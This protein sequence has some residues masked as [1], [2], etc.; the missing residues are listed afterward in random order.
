[1]RHTKARRLLPA[2]ALAGVAVLLG[3]ALMP[4]GG[5]GGLLLPGAAALSIGPTI[6]HGPV[7]LV[8][9]TFEGYSAGDWVA[10]GFVASAPDAR[11]QGCTYFPSVST[12]ISGKLAIPARDISRAVGFNITYSITA[13][14][15]FL[16]LLP[17]GA[18]G[19]FAA[20]L[21][22]ARER[23]VTRRG[24]CEI[25]TTHCTWVYSYNTV[26]RAISPTATVFLSRRSVPR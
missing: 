12:A 22:Y 13:G 11:W 18:W 23:V 8:K 15:G 1:M 26:Q 10:C 7:Q 24:E 3:L 2:S 17:P 14:H 20:G 19:T 5:V 4:F 9:K 25:A 6:V 21:E 16:T